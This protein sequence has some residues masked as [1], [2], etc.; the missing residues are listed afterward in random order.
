MPGLSR[1]AGVGGNA[2]AGRN[3]GLV[4]MT[5]LAGMMGLWVAKYVI[6]FPGAPFRAGPFCAV[7]VSGGAVAWG[8]VGLR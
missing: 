6:P 3:A 7:F 5:G 8:L 2:V 4:G 1:D